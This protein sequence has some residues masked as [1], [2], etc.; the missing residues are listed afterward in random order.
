MKKYEFRF[1]KLL[2]IKE[3]KEIEAKQAY[4]TVLR[5][6]INI[7]LE[8]SKMEKDVFAAAEEDFESLKNGEPIDFLTIERQNQ[9][10]H[11]VNVWVKK[12]NDK[13]K[14]VEVD[15]VQLKENLKITMVE[16]KKIEKLEEKEKKKYHREAKKEEI[17][18][19]DETKRA[20]KDE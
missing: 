19:L 16:K 14:S 20:K 13:K 1:N 3:H 17:K 6:K 12:N 4:A 18:N 11:A 5:Q 2:K 10:S 8:N 15:L 7:E 9:F